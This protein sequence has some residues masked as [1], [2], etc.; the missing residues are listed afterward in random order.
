M[1]IILFIIIAASFTSCISQKK[2]NDRYPPQIITKDSVVEREVVTYRDTTIT[3]PGDSVKIHD[4]IPCP[5]VVYHKEVKSKSGRTTAKVDINKGTLTVECKT[6]SLQRVIDSLASVIKTKEV[7]KTT[8]VIKEKPVTKY[9]I[10]KWCW[11]YI[12]ITLGYFVWTFR[13]P[14]TAFIKKLWS[15]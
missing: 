4:T 11:W 2:C 13:S 9:R 1:R 6:D 15:R 7:Y 10:P 8:T 3:V 14:I 12:G 5:D